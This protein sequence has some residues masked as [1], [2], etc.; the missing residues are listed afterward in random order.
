MLPEYENIF[1]GGKMTQG[2]LH[3]A[4]YCMIVTFISSIHIEYLQFPGALNCV[5][6]YGTLS[7]ASA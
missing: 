7:G 2:I 3:A 4:Q 5:I 1:E 6:E